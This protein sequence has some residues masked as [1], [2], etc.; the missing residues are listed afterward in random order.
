MCIKN[1]YSVVE[2]SIHVYNNSIP[3]A[4]VQ[5]ALGNGNTLY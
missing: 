5:I 2:Q 3:I 4:S 1:A